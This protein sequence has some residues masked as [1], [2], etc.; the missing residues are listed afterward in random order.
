VQRARKIIHVDMDAFFASVEQRDHPEYRGR[1]VIVGGSPARRGVVATASYEARRF[2]VHSAMSSAR[3]VRLCPH[4]V[5]VPPRF[6]A[7]KAVSR[8]IREIF[9]RFTDLVEPLSL[10]EAYLD[11][12]ENKP[13]IPS[14]TRIAREI[15]RLI[16]LE[17]GLTASA[18]VAPNKFIAKL[19]TEVNKPDGLTVV[20]PEQVDD[21]LRDL[22]VRKIHGIGKATELKMLELGIET[23]S[24][25]RTWSEPALVHRFGKTGAW[26]HQLARGQD[27]RPVV[28]HQPRKSIGAEETFDR[29][30]DDLEWLGQQLWD[31]SA[32]V[33]GYV[34][35][36]G[37]VAR[38]VT[39]KVT[40]ADF[41]KITRSRTLEHPVADT[42]ALWQVARA[43][44]EHT[45]VGPRKVRL[46]GVSVHNPQ[47]ERVAG[48][49]AQ[50]PLP[51]GQSGAG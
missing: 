28:P 22:P 49:G 43:L 11:V 32:R 4:A 21:F 37:F 41:E 9:F 34:Q 13:G 10:D 16:R 26:Y 8:Q 19:A 46:L 27:D 15:R 33:V 1:P 44:L 39:L 42:A 36:S 23:V 38:T 17:T 31:L 25:L 6:E 7:Y 50:L 14:A 18:G 5:F 12:T 29:D 2:G 51:F 40:Y 48:I 45:E 30:V 24:D 3:A 20:T 47:L 35:K